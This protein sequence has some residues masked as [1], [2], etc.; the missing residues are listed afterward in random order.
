MAVINGVTITQ[1]QVFD[2]N[3]ANKY[4]IKF[5][6]NFDF[7]PGTPFVGKFYARISDIAA[8]SWHTAV[9]ELT[10]QFG[11]DYQIET[12]EL[13]KDD[14]VYTLELGANETDFFTEKSAAGSTAPV[15][16]ARY[17][18]FNALFKNDI[19]TLKWDAPS[20]NILSG[21]L[22]FSGDLVLSLALPFGV[23][24]YSLP[25]SADIYGDN[26]Q[27]TVSAVPRTFNSLGQD[28][29]FGIPTSEITVLTAPPEIQ[30][31]SLTENGQ[32]R[33]LTLKFSLS[34]KYAQ[35]LQNYQAIMALT[36]NGE[37]PLAGSVLRVDVLQADIAADGN[38]LTASLDVSQI[39][40]LS[41]Y[42]AYLFI[43]SKEQTFTN[44][45]IADNE[46]SLALPQIQVSSPNCN[47][48]F[49]ANFGI[50]PNQ[51]LTV[52][53]VTIGTGA[54]EIVDVP[55]YNIPNA[56]DYFGQ[57]ITIT[58]KFS[59]KT[60]LSASADIFLRGYYVKTVSGNPALIY[61]HD[62]AGYAGAT[63]YTLNNYFVQPLTGDIASEDGLLSMN[64]DGVSLTVKTVLNNANAN[65]SRDSFDKWIKALFD[66]KLSVKGYYKIRDLVARSAAFNLA[67]APYFLL[68]IDGEDKTAD[69]LPG[70]ILRVRTSD[71]MMQP[72]ATSNAQGYIQSC[73]ADFQ[74][75]LC[76]VDTAPYIGFDKN[77]DLTIGAWGASSEHPNQN[78]FGGA[79]DFFRVTHKTA[80]M[81]IVSPP[82]GFYESSAVTENFANANMTIYC[83]NDLNTL[84]LA[85]ANKDIPSVPYFIFRGRAVLS[86]CIRVFIGE[87]EK[88]VP[89]GTTLKD[90]ALAAG[91]SE[92][93]GL[94]FYRRGFSGEL[95]PVFADLSPIGDIPL[96]PG[97]K[98][99][100]SV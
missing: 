6:V 9:K 61:A 36:P 44:Y 50:T 26:A 22:R 12:D 16:V 46:I 63:V 91:V 20:Y 2:A 13:V 34:E 82:G 11:Q 57:K 81:R 86:T 51:G 71:F 96:A 79:M 3:A 48:A 1:V 100:A 75:A 78:I 31:A 49:V 39:K 66:A 21:S 32:A 93:S 58:P 94:K 10:Y 99:V 98:I 67:D 15:L 43:Q 88:T 19:L 7:S 52:F 60:G 74:T 53:G 83:S 17:K 33:T 42:R 68:G 84:N 47:A 18:N 69:I 87:E 45:S 30:S 89:A 70:S 62:P 35:P 76:G 23:K 90:I 54:E 5:S 59:D 41:S 25:L 8:P 27:F 92:L 80:F 40:G 37:S 97:D 4:T 38:T 73:E 28:T 24:G 85:M 56:S 72:K 55:Y 14:Y 95:L 29:F 65:L 64:K 77:L